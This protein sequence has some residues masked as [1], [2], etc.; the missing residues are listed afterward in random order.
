MNRNVAGALFGAAV[1]SF[2]SI[3]Y[4]LSGVTP[5][6]GGFYR[7]A[8]ALPFLA[9]I[10]AVRREHD[11]RTKG[12]RYLA[13]GAGLVLSLDMFAW[14]AAIGYLGAGLATL[15]TNGQVL[16]VGLI[17][18]VL[19][20]E[21]PT[22][23]VWFST[24]IVL[25]GLA[26]VSGLGRTDTYGTR[27]V[28]GTALA[29][30]AS[31]SY[32]LFLVAFRRSNRSHAPTAGPLLE[33]TLG[34]CISFTFFGLFAPLDYTPALASFAWLAL[35]A[36]S[37]QVVGWLLIGYSLPR[38]PASESATIILFQPVAAMVWARLIFEERPSGTQLVGAA[39][40]LVG[41]GLVAIRS[42]FGSIQS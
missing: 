17:T 31:I 33:S 22:R 38:L 3:L 4:R 19:F 18:W 30:A 2:S 28:L 8:V 37:S 36:V 29:V 34:A 24:P 42:S 20:K 25:I 5:L 35:L 26:M 1:I 10:W 14:H 41:V 39:I 7:T 32:A 6:T 12:E 23:V 15:V 11:S 16:M 21:K 27:P 40:V 9:V 13:L